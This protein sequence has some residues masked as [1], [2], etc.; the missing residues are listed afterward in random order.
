MWCVSQ[1]QPFIRQI[2]GFEQSLNAVN[3]LNIKGKKCGRS[4]VLKFVENKAMQPYLY[5]TF[6]TK[7]RL[8]VLHIETL[9]YNKIIDKRKHRQ[10]KK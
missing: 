7:G 1:I 9:L 3:N 10:F 8:K 4:S 2:K 5:S 6:H